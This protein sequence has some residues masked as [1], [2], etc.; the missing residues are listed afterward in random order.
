MVVVTRLFL[1]CLAWTTLSE[2]FTLFGVLDRVVSRALRGLTK[3]R[4][5]VVAVVPSIRVFFVLGFPCV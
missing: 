5:Q 1:Y 3:R 4:Q 2:R